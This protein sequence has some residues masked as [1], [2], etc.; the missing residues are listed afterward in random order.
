VESL[1]AD[2]KPSPFRWTS[3]LGASIR[4]MLSAEQEATTQRVLAVEPQRFFTPDKRPYTI[5]IADVQITMDDEATRFTVPYLELVSCKVEAQPGS[6]TLRVAGI[7]QDIVA[8]AAPATEA[9]FQKVCEVVKEASDTW[10]A[11]NPEIAARG[12]LGVGYSR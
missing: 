4:Q 9:A 6:V 3:E 8:V 12:P 1:Q 7:R 10:K 5:T 11:H 2:A